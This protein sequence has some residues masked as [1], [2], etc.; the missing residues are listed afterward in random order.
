MPATVKGMLARDL[1]ADVITR[2]TS[3][4]KAIEA[5]PEEV[6]SDEMEVFYNAA[7]ANVKGAL[8]NVKLL[9]EEVS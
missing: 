4:K 5:I 2:L 6:L 8:T 3:V 9:L 1:S 7:L